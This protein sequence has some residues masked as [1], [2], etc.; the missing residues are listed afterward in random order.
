MTHLRIRKSN[1]PCY[2]HNIITRCS[3]WM[4]GSNLGPNY[5]SN[6]FQGMIDEF[7]IWGRALSEVESMVQV[8]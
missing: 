2:N 3:D 6:G 4:I 5:L 1:T 8:R 7:A